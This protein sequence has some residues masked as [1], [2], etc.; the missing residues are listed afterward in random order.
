[1]E[2]KS[3]LFKRIFIYILAIIIIIL[4]Y[5]FVYY[6]AKLLL[7][8]DET[9]SKYVYLT[10]RNSYILQNVND[11]LLKNYYKD[12][13]IMVVFFAS[14]CHYCVEEEHELNN[15]ITNNPLKKII[16][17]SHDKNY[18]DMENYLKDKNFKWFVIY[19]KDKKIRTH[20]D[21]GISGIPATYLI[22]TNGKI[23]GYKKGKLTEEEFLKLYNNEI[24]IYE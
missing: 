9:Y 4:L 10:N 20:I 1:M 7:N 13:K 24:Y 6:A 12:E 22:D 18:E 19:D 8:P 14:W 2:N 15:F 11:N 17:V 21:P 16:V 5:I 23:I 3:I